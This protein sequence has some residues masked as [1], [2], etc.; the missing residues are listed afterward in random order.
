MT[1]LGVEAAKQVPALAVLTLLTFWFLREMRARDKDFTATIMEAEA[2]HTAAVKEMMESSNRI[3]QD[4]A[5]V[6]VDL[7][8][9]VED[10][11]KLVGRLLEVQPAH[12]LEAVRQ[13]EAKVD[14]SI[15]AFPLQRDG[16]R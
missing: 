12:V 11:S 2:R 9:T 5:R 10:H 15:E 8:R 14:K 6:L 1:E 4:T 13:L 3:H 7:E 16:L